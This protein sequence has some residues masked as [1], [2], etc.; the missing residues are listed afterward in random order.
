MNPPFSTAVRER[1][2]AAAAR[3]KPAAVGLLLVAE[4]P[5]ESSDRYF[6]F[7]EVKE[8]ETLFRETVRA[9]LGEEP[10]RTKD[11][12]L[13]ELRRKGVFLIDLKPDPVSGRHEDLCDRSICSSSTPTAFTL[14]RLSS[15]AFP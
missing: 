10:R 13:G 4:A 2:A 11:E 1:R 5:P 3:Y 15:G 14:R 6:Y 7:E 12:Q 9:L 8:H